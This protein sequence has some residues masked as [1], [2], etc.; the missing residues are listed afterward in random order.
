VDSAALA[1]MNA[2]PGADVVRASLI[3]AIISS[4]NYSEVMKKTLERSVAVE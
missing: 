2:E 4:V 1:V 3:G